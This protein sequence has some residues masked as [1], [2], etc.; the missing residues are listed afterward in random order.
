MSVLISDEILNASH[1]SE[2]EL[3]QEI[4]ILLYQKEK[5][6]LVQASKL[7]GMGII[8]FQ[9]LLASRDICINYNIDDFNH[10][11]QTLENIHRI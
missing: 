9:H 8:Q 2:Q 1:M 6:T 4:A 10:D 5:L 7:A 3:K 11:V